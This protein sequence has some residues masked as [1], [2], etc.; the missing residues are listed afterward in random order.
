MGKKSCSPAELAN[1]PELL[2]R[3]ARGEVLNV[4]IGPDGSEFG[5]VES[6]QAGLFISTEASLFTQLAW[7]F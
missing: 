3:V 4:P 2:R 6:E 7:Y 1:N 5:G